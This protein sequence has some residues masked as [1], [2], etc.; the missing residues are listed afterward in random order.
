[1]AM[2]AILWTNSCSWLGGPFLNNPGIL[3]FRQRPPACHIRIAG[4]S[5]D[6]LKEGRG[7]R[8]LA[9]LFMSIF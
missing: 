5:V 9:V 2:A 1:M 6:L 3:L 4:S 8:K 7:A